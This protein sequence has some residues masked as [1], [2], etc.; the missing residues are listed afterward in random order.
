MCIIKQ[1]TSY[2][3]GH[4]C[5]ATILNSSLKDLREKYPRKLTTE[6]IKNVLSQN[7]YKTKIEFKINEESFFLPRFGIINVPFSNEGHWVIIKGDKVFCPKFGI[8]KFE[9]YITLSLGIVTSMITFKKERFLIRKIK[10]MF[11]GIK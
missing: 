11:R 4:A 6:D 3:C 9:H 2:D 10:S 8:F 7:G 1:E 5:L